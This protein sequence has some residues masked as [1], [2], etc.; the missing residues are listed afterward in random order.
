MPVD[1]LPFD[2]LYL[3]ILACSPPASRAY[4]IDSA[5]LHSLCRVSKSFK[6]IATPI[7]YSSIIL[8]TPFSLL[9][10]ASTAKENP[11]LLKSCH[12]LFLYLFNTTTLKQAVE[13]IV[14]RTSA[15][16]RSI[17]LWGSVWPSMLSHLGTVCEV[18]ILG[19]NYYLTSKVA[20]MFEN[21]ECL[22]LDNIPFQQHHVVDAMVTM[23]RLTHF[24]VRDVLFVDIHANGP[25]Y[26]Q[27]IVR[28]LTRTNLKRMV[29]GW[30]MTSWT[31][32]RPVGYPYI[33]TVH[34]RLLASL[35]ANDQLKLVFLKHGDRGADWFTDRVVDG[36][37][38]ELESC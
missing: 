14:S 13:D 19:Q 2:I 32:T 1:Q 4:G 22:T 21:L 28:M 6:D 7:L 18:A 27:G 20:N 29:V 11:Q 26:E 17:I 33:D 25:S 35:P 30:N 15:L 38:W 31:W 37:V 16:H 5:T 36:T 12:S 8:S 34:Q 23:P 3:V 9:S 10:L 24:A